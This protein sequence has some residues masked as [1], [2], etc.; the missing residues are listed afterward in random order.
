MKKFL[1]ILSVAFLSS[2]TIAQV[3]EKDLPLQAAAVPAQDAKAKVE[4][5]AKFSA[6]KAKGNFNFQLPATATTEAV[7]KAAGYYKQYFTVVYNDKTKNAKITMIENDSRGRH[8][9]VRFL[10][11]NGVR[12]ISMDGKDYSI[13]DFWSQH[14]N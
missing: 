5:A 9:I 6:E 13:D 3:A 14:M 4:S 1:T 2:A 10:V 7:N 11:S 8:V 12:E